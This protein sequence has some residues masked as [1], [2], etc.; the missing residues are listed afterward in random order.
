MSAHRYC[1][2]QWGLKNF[3]NIFKGI[4]NILKQLYKIYMRNVALQNQLE[5]KFYEKGR[6]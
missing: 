5:R 1:Y 4:D 6:F 2:T 3:I